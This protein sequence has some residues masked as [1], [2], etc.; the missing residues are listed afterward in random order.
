MGVAVTFPTDAVDKTEP[1]GI[2]ALSNL[3][4]TPATCGAAI[5][6]PDSDAAPESEV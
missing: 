5:E 1:A 3:A 2:L 4:I 6:V